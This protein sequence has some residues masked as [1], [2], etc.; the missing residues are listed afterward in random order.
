MKALTSLPTSSYLKIAD[1]VKVPL[2]DL[3]ELVPALESGLLPA[4]VA[5]YRPDIS[6][7]LD[8]E[9]LYE[10]LQLLHSF[11][12]L[13]DRRITVLAALGQKNQLTP[14]LRARIEAL[15]ERQALED[16]YLPFRNR[17]PSAADRA[18]EQGLEPLANFLWDQ[19]PANTDID[20]VAGKYV[21]SHK[22]IP[23]AS[24]ALT[25]AHHIV[26]RR[27]ADDPEIR[28]K[29]R[30][31]C[32]KHTELQINDGKPRRTDTA[33]RKK[34]D[35]LK[36]YRSLVTEVGWRQHLAL[37]FGIREGLLQSEFILPEGRILSFM[38]EKFL[39]AESSLF[40]SHLETAAHIAYHD[41]LATPLRDD[42]SR[43]LADRSDAEALRVFKKNLRKTLLSPPAGTLRT[44]GL[45][46]GKSGGWRAAVVGGNG[47][48]PRVRRSL[49][50]PAP[51]WGY[52]AGRDRRE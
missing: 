43:W 19:D 20:V 35:W 14:E 34:T 17:R 5:H 52:S 21:D 32:I 40:R 27:L 7:G 44:I 45:E 26:A 23:N 30:K 50:L 49:S 22:G 28:D 39:K 36:G 42:V 51:P 31:I 10:I 3:L 46:M 16:L 9:H 25:N 2:A 6:S 38:L 15:T 13:E 18:L 47:D 4:Y 41:Y 12:D 48:L 33:S 24:A 37:R 8:T 1:Q 11:L 29:L